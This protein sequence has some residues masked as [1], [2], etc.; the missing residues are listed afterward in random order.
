MAVN[1]SPLGGVA[2]QFFN[3]DGVPLAGGLIYTYTAGT[4]TPANTYTTGAGTVPHS[5]PI[6]LD[7]AGRVPTGEIW[8]TDSLAYKFVIK[9][10]SLTLIGTYD[11]IVGINSNFVNYTASQEIQTATAGQTVFTL[12]TMAYQ[13]GTNSLSVF[14]DGVNQYGPGAQYAFVETSSTSVTFASGLHV[15]A[16]VKFTTA[17]INN[18]GGVDASQVTYT[19]PYA[20]SVVSNVEAKLSESISVLDFGADPTGVANSSTAIANAINALPAAG[21]V[22]TFPPGEYLG[23]IN[24]NRSNVKIDGFGATL[25]SDGA[26]PAVKIQIPSG[27]IVNVCVYGLTIDGGNAATH[28][29]RIVRA[30]RIMIDNLFIKNF[31]DHGI[32]IT[33]DGVG[34]VTQI[35]AQMCRIDAGN[36]PAAGTA[37][38]RIG[39]GGVATT[40]RLINNYITAYPISLSDDGVNTVDLGNIYEY[41]S[42]AVV[43]NGPNVYIGDWVETG[44]M[45][46]TNHYVIEDGRT[47][48]ISPHG[49]GIANVSS[50]APGQ[51]PNIQNKIMMQDLSVQGPTL[52]AEGG[53]QYY[54][55]AVGGAVLASAPKNLRGLVQV[56]G[57]NTS[58]TVT[59]VSA[60]PNDSYFIVATPV[61]LTNTPAA[62]SNRVTSI[63]KTA[64]GFTLNVETAPGGTA[65]VTFNWIMVR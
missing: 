4:N 60:E 31:N 62:G 39:D 23:H 13:P 55:P 42:N 50:G 33:G 56:S 46:T 58:A 48:I 10:A 40:V 52:M 43:S 36:A 47:T 5:N 2:A 34:S 38:I 25:V 15:G 59:F 29:V 22:I 49:S 14:V 7:S 61:Q 41:A 9:D 32:Y 21:G 6:V 53:L 16:S 1:L 26:N 51:F 35:Q 18:I 54:N 57:T 8:L 63:S 24:I 3:N 12:T 45:Y 44:S 37:G 65:I 28:G 30:T 17:V 64:S 11:N 27:I 19:A 20:N